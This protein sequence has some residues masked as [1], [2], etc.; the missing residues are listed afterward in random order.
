MRTTS[1]TFKTIAGITAGAALLA[2]TGCT[3]MTTSKSTTD[4]SSGR[5]HDD[6]EISSK[7]KS[8]LDHNPVYKFE[9]VRVNTFKGVVQLSG[10][11][12]TEDQ[13]Q[14][15]GE[16]AKQVGWVHDI[17]NNISI[18]PREEYPTATGR[19]TGERGTSS[20]TDRSVPPT[21]PNP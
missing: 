21:N 4:R 7:V 17:V 19:A 6:K 15:A 13:R 3:S 8:A 18:K 5:V 12:D 14:K 1:R 11:V 10:F 9:E 20:G 16:V 2:I